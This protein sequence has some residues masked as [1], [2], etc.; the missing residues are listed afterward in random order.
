MVPLGLLGV[1]VTSTSW[2]DGVVVALGLLTPVLLLRRWTPEGYPDGSILALVASAASW[3]V[4]A[5]FLGSPMA[6]FAFSLAGAMVLPRLPRRRGIAVVGLCAVAAAIGAL[7]FI[8]SP[9]TPAGA[10]KYLLIPVALT[11]FIY[12]VLALVERYAVI[13]LSLE[14]AKEA[15]AEL[16]VAR[17]RVRFA[18][19]LHDIQGHTLHVIKLK[20]A[21]ARRL[22]DSD[23]AAAARELDE[24]QRLIG[25]TIARTQDLVHAQRRLNI[26]SELEN[27]KNLLEAAGIAVTVTTINPAADSGSALLAQVLRETTTNILRHS[28]ST[29]ATITVDTHRIEI[30]N[31]GAGTGPVPALGGLDTLRRRVEEGGGKL[32][33]ARESGSFRTT[34]T[35]PSAH[36]VPTA[37]TSGS[38][39]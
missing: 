34:A 8:A 29:H 25:E 6:V 11:A 20:T 36:P 14:R 32:D 39:R 30:V 26:A 27:A 37:S 2:W 19:D 22:T 5:V 24:V 31:D 16:A 38:D 12:L 1:A 17:E 23:P 9:F 33:V 15:E 10:V 21:L 3:G 4:N 28:N 35:A 18:G 7:A 13:L